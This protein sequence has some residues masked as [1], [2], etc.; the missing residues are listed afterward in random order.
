MVGDSLAHDI[1]GARGLGMRG[2]LVVRAGRPAPAAPGVVVV[3]SL[4]E[5]PDLLLR[6]E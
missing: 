5:L 4:R 1:E 3:R 6:S 2:I